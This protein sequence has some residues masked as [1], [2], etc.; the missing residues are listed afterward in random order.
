MVCV[1][2]IVDGYVMG[3][4]FEEIVMLYYVLFDV[5][6]VVDVVFVKGGKVLIDFVSELGDFF[7]VD[8]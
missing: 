5:G 4:W 2:W 8:C 7:I 6:F 1:N 3:V